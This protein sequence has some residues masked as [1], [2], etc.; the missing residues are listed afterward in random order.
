MSGSA[1][2]KTIST[3]LIDDEEIA[4]HRLK[5]ELAVYPV[6]NIIGEAHDGIAAVEIINSLRPELIFLDIQMPGLNGFEVISRLDYLP[7]VV[8]VTAFEEYAIRAFEKNS[9]DYLLKPIESK[10]LAITIARITEKS[11]T[12]NDTVLKIRQLIKNTGSQ[13]LIT[14]LP[15]KQGNK[16][17]LVHINDIY[18]FEARDKYVYIHTG[19]EEKLIDYSLSYLEERLPAEFVRVHRSFIISKLKIREVHKHFKGTF[20]FVMNNRKSSTIRSAYSY[21]E[22]IR[23]KLLTP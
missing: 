23:Q 19:E 10:R 12:D 1:F 15:V 7:M 2:Q 4:I 3:L 16:I 21:S 5:K 9:V 22:S 14:T 17:T 18:F 20:M 13:Q 6:I 11:I 8:F